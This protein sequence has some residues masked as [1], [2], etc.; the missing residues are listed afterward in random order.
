MYSDVLVYRRLRI[1]NV[2]AEFVASEPLAASIRSLP[3]PGSS[4]IASP[5]NRVQARPLTLTC[6][7]F[8]PLGHYGA[9][10]QKKTRQQSQALGT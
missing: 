8:S 5:S 9:G 6:L 2:R 3:C 1:G 4:R 10:R 7:I